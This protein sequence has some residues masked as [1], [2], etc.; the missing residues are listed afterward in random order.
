MIGP[1]G[2]PAEGVPITL[3]LDHPQAGNIWHPPVLTDLQGR[4]RFDDLSPSLR[5]YQAHLDLRHAITS[6]STPT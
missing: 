1:D 3:E 5:V 4:F 6:R 2:L